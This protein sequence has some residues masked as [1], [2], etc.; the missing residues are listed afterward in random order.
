MTE[1]AITAGRMLQ[2]CVFIE[3][4]LQ[5]GLSVRQLAARAE[6]SSFHFQRVF[7]QTIGES[8]ARYVRRLRLERAALWLRNSDAPITEIALGSGFDSHAGFTHA[9]TKLYGMSPSVWRESVDVVPFVRQPHEGRPVPD[10]AALAGCP[11]TV[12]LVEVP[13]Q[14]LAIMRFTGPTRKLPA[15]WPRMIEWCRQQQVLS[16]EMHFFG[17]HYDDWDAAR[18]GIYRYDAAVTVPDDYQSCGE[19]AVLKQAGGLVATVAFEGSLMQL[20]RTWQTFV[21]QW[22]PASGY[23]FRLN[24]VFDEYPRELVCGSR[25]RT[26][27][28]AL[29]GL[30]ARLCIPVS[31]EWKETGGS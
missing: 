13:S 22:L 28:R 23:Q 18:D 17:L 11:L 26:I 2:T 6:M 4:N 21:R 14:T 7:R 24:H 16:D 5:N 20:D 30:K 9:F 12:S 15:V 1:N 31:R 3:A 27:V 8:A 10:A 19:V 25:L 29:S